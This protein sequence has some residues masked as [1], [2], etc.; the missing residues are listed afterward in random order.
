MYLV[1][2]QILLRFYQFYM[3]SFVCVPREVHEIL[4]R[5]D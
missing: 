5:I 3:H 2:P 4:S 1:Y